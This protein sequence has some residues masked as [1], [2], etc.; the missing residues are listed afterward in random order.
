MNFDLASFIIGFI[1]AIV[2]V[3]VIE[4]FQERLRQKKNYE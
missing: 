2:V 3:I 4:Y 1:V